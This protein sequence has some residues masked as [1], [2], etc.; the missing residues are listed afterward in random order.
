MSDWGTNYD[1][2]LEY[3]KQHGT[4]NIPQEEIFEC[5]FEGGYHFV[6]RLGTWLRT[7]RSLKAGTARYRMKPER[8]VLLQK[9]V[10]EGKS[11]VNI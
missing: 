3:Y 11:N 6:G 9:L 8:K 1:A 5:Y 2:L 7:Q 10:D 4:C